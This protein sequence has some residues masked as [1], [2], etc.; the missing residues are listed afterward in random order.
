MA[1]LRNVSRDEACSMQYDEWSGRFYINIFI[2]TPIMVAGW[3]MNS[4]IVAVFTELK[5]SHPSIHLLKCLALA[6][7]GYLI[8]HFLAD[9]L[10]YLLFYINYGDKVFIDPFNIYPGMFAYGTYIIRIAFMFQRNW[11]T[12]LIQTERFLT[13]LYPLKAS[14]WWTKKRMNR[15]IAG[16]TVLFFI[17]PIYFPFTLKIEDY[18]D[19]CHGP[20]N[21]LVFKYPK[22][23]LLC[24]KLLDPVF[25]LILPCAIILV[26]NTALI[27]TLYVKFRQRKKLGAQ[28]QT[29]KGD[30]KATRMVISMS[31]TFLVLEIPATFSKVR[32]YALPNAIIWELAMDIAYVT[33]DIDSCVN[34]ILYCVV[35]RQF[36][37]TLRKLTCRKSVK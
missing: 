29:L 15:I 1:S 5:S 17:W 9:T 18:I 32:S 30:S 11:L 3:V 10:R 8:G 6:D 13:I 16:A 21:R 28:Q 19:P 25:R 33:S 26:V 37:E 4:L 14:Q 36:Y 34:F 20:N 7:I 35:N 23:Y 31:I 2:L 24:N 12:V 27:V 22:I